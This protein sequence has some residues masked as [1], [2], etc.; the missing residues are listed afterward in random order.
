MLPAIEPAGT[1]TARQIVL[2]AFMLL[3]VSLGP[4]FF[5][6]EG[7]VFLI[8]AAILGLWFLYAAIGAARYKTNEK[9]KTLVVVSIIYL[10]LLFLLM[11]ADK[12]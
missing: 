8:G 3:P 7:L 10:P 5:G 11:V 2:F 9:A 1:I 12:R 4:Y 6:R